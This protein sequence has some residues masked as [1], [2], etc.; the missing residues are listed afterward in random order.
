MTINHIDKL[1][2]SSKKALTVTSRHDLL[3][4]GSSL[5]NT[6][7]IPA[8]AGMTVERIPAPVYPGFIRDRNKV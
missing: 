2:K 1:V 7:W 8:Y 4:G 6:F 3:S 5:F